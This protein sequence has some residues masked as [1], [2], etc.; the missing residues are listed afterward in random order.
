MNMH[1]A[2]EARLQFLEPQ[3]FEFQDD[4]HLHAGHAGNQ[5]GGHYSITVASRHFDN[6]SRLQRQR[7]VKDA[8]QDLFS[9][10]L[11]HALSMRTLTPDEYFS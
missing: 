1:Q 9:Q 8:L 7:M 11:I 2:I 6:K 10:G 4:S 5:G 3:V